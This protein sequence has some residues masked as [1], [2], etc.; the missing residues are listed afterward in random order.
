MPTPYS[1][2]S[3]FTT[4]S[5]MTDADKATFGSDPA[6]RASG[7]ESALIRKSAFESRITFV[8]G[9]TPWQRFGLSEHSLV[10]AC[11]HCAVST[12]SKWWHL[13]NRNDVTAATTSEAG[14]PW[15][16]RWW[17]FDASRRCRTCRPGSVLRRLLPTHFQLACE[18]TK[19]LFKFVQWW[20]PDPL[21]QNFRQY[22]PIAEGMLNLISEKVFWLL[23][24]YSV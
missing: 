10:I 19:S 5:E 9:S 3:I 12:A 6:D 16:C 8:W 20:L 24:K 7:S 15:W 2:R 13:A 23:T 1:H 22:R 18:K 14:I 17:T 11:A 21:K 4:L